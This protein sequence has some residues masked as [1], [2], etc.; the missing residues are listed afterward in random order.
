MTK[1]RTWTLSHFTKHHFNFT[2]L[3]AYTFIIT[4]M[5]VCTLSIGYIWN[6]IV[7]SSW[8]NTQG[9]VLHTK[10]ERVTSGGGGQEVVQVPLFHLS[11]LLS[12]HILLIMR[13]ILEIV[14]RLAY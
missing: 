9:R 12:I 14:M 5:I 7:S 8:P 13:N 4:G 2:M 1:K 10:V 6:G 11:L 3:V